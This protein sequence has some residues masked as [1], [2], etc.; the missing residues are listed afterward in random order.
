MPG[1]PPSGAASAASR[2]CCSKTSRARCRT[3]PPR[4]TSTSGCKLS[5]FDRNAHELLLT[6]LAR[7]GRIA[8]GEAHLASASKLFEAD[9]LDSAPLRDIWRSAR[10]QRAAHRRSRARRSSW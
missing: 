6:S 3:K 1:S 9:G 4:P 5:P 2:P 8:E 10:E 7:Q